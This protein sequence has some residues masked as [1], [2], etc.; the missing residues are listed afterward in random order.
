M[1]KNL[2][3]RKL[4]IVIPAYNEE[5]SI[6]PLYDEIKASVA[7]LIKN[8]KIQDY[9]ILFVNDGS[10]DNTEKNIVKLTA[11]KRVKLISLRKNFGKSKA[12]QIGFQ[13]ICGD[14]IVTM[15]A[16][17]QDDPTELANFIAKLDEGYDMVSGW[18]F[19]RLDPLEKTLPSK[20]FNFVTSKVSGIKIHDFNCGF[21]AYRK[22][23]VKSLNI[24]GEFHRYIPVLALRNGF[25]ITEITVK[26]HKRQFGKSKFGMERYLRGMFDAVSALFLLKF[27]D[28]PMYFFGKIG[29]GLLMVGFLICSYLTALWFAG[30]AIGGRP[31]LILGILFILVGFQSFSLGLIANIIIDNVD[32][33]GNDDVLISKTVNEESSDDA[34]Q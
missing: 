26:H 9:E 25:R 8:H 31:L 12:L 33:R 24:Y 16:D 23:V 11:D 28:K 18:K 5:D 14:I 13:H 20:L 3:S 15:D 6:K 34:I 10:S 19:N 27:Y 30:Y 17:L 4:S 29:L 22:E 2:N 7:K 21:K 1:Q 32:K